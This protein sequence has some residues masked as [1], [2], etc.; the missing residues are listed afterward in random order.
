MPVGRS[1][2]VNAIVQSGLRSERFWRLI[3]LGTLVLYSVWAGL[4]IL[5]NPGFQYDEALLVLGSVQMRHSP[6]ELALPHD[7]HSWICPDGRCFPLMTV[8]YVGA[9]KEYL[10]LPLFAAFGPGATILRVVS[11]LL[12]ALGIWGIAKLMADHVSPASAAATAALL[13][14]NPAYA[15]LTVFDNGTVSIWMGALGILCLAIAGYLRRPSAHS[16]FWLGVSM[17]LGVWA[18][19]NFLWMLIAIAAARVVILGRRILAPLSHWG[20]L[21]LGGLLGGA[22]FLAYQIVSGGCTWQALGMFPANQPLGQR[23][24]LRLVMFGETLLSDREHR[25]MWD[26]PSMPAWQMWLFACAVFAACLV[27]LSARG[28]SVWPRAVALCFL[29]LAAFLFLSKMIVA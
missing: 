20:A 14:I 25:A 16:A 9:I 23:I 10:C 26:G 29:F 4:L 17:G 5:Q 28:R 6:Q 8:R 3:V 13:A 2:A 1:F 22:P 18:R 15:D 21:L 27:C 12:G 11:G 24:Y 19:A 7:P